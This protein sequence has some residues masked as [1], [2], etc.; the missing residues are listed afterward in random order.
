MEHYKGL[1]FKTADYNKLTLFDKLDITMR[2]V[3][4]DNIDTLIAVITNKE[5]DFDAISLGYSVKKGSCLIIIQLVLE[6]CIKYVELLF[7]I[8][9]KSYYIVDLISMAK[10]ISLFYNS[11]IV[12]FTDFMLK[13]LITVNETIIYRDYY[14]DGMKQSRRR[15]CRKEQ[16][17]YIMYDETNGSYKLGVSNNPI[18]RERTLQSDKPYVVLLHR[19]KANHEDELHKKYAEQRLR[20]EWFN[21]TDK[22]L[23]DIVSGYE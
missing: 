12:D 13:D 20:G 9:R 3:D 21:L 18:Y 5:F 23:T 1:K 16:P 17:S 7:P 15:V 10:I 19:F 11:C 2:N 4:I 6:G 14:T 22:Q 8:D